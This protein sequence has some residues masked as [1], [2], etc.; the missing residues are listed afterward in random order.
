[1]MWRQGIYDQELN[2]LD[3]KVSYLRLALKITEKHAYP[4]EHVPED[5]EG[6][7]RIRWRAENW[8]WHRR[9]LWRCFCESKKGLR[10]LRDAPIKFNIATARQAAKIGG[11]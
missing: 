2:S 10:T 9:K 5:L 8:R 4:P 11:G 3:F 1:M 7:D 6:R